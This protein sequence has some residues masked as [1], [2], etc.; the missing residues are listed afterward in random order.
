MKKI[1]LISAS[2]LI[3][4]NGSNF[5]LAQD[6]SNEFNPGDTGVKRIEEEDKITVPLD[7]IDEVW[8]FLN[9]HYIKDASSIKA[10]S[11]KISAST[12]NEDFTDTYFDTPKLELLAQKDGVRH[13]RRYNLT[14]PEDR[15]SG[16]E[17][18]QIKTS[19]ISANALQRAEVKFDVKYP[20][21]ISSREDSHPVI[22]LIDPGQRQEFKDQ[23]TA[24]GINPESLK[25]ILTLYDQRQRIYWSFDGKPFISFSLN[26]VASNLFWAKAEFAEIE[27]ELNEVT[28]TEASV[29]DRKYMEE[30]NAKII[31]ELKS[32]LPYLK[33]DLT[34]KYNKT[35]NQFASKIPFL[36][37]FIRVDKKVLIWTPI[38]TV[39]AIFLIYLFAKD[40]AIK[41]RKGK[42]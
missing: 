23:V 30:V 40:R 5:V 11:P 17:L 38:F 28:F 18:V 14:N 22:G 27:P 26:H 33:S 16:R 7:K 42:K 3:L 36:K 19:G 2:I 25:P 13:R 31:N 6:Q 35:F 1:I 34:P 9:D 21:K 8:K 4:L 37:S 39:L 15:K 41:V 10:I 20:T 29:E 24:L 32:E 12:A